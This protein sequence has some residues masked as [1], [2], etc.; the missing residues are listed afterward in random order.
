[1]TRKMTKHS[2][3]YALMSSTLGTVLV[4]MTAVWLAT[5][6]YAP[7]AAPDAAS[8]HRSHSPSSSSHRLFRLSPIPPGADWTS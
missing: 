5:A 4:S 2:F 6:A 1:M 7:V 8:A 3:P